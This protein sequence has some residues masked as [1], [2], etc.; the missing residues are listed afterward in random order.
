MSGKQ[1][2]TVIVVYRPPKA[3]K[4]QFIKEVCILLERITTSREH[5]L[6]AGDFNLNSNNKT[7]PE[8]LKFHTKLDQ[9]SLKQHVVGSTHIKGH[10]LDVIITRVDMDL[11]K[12]VK[13][14]LVVDH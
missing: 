9:F 2:L 1:A 6:I 4:N 3:N 14:C 8:T 13:E 10:L 7:L 12:P 11:T 5:L